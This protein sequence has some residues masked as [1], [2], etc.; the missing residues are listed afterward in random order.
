MIDF[1]KD[2]SIAGGFL[3]CRLPGRASRTRQSTVMGMVERRGGKVPFTEGELTAMRG[4]LTAEE[5][6]QRFMREWAQRIYRRP[7][8]AAL[9]IVVWDIFSASC[10]LI[11]LR[12]H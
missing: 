3:F 9:F 12:V 7:R 5:H 11:A 2:I 10:A 6:R 8:V 4:R 1:I